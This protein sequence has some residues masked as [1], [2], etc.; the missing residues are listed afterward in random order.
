VN[1]FWHQKIEDLESALPPYIRL[2][3]LPNYGSVK[4]RL[5]T[6]GSVHRDIE[7]EITDWQQKIKNRIEENVIA[8]EDLKIEDVLGRL[9]LDKK[10]NVATAESCTGGMIGSRISDV[11]GSS[12]YFKGAVVSYAY[13]VK[14]EVLGVDPE[15]LL[16]E[17]AVSEY[18]V[19]KM[20]QEVLNVMNAEVSVAVSGILGPGGATDEKPLGTVWMA[21]A[22]K[23]KTHSKVFHF[24]YDR[25]R[26][27][28]SVVQAALIGLI[29][30]IQ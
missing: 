16:R 13:D 12:R 23:E 24:R 28:E 3:Y 15:H 6:H 25:W 5:T 7:K 8:E 18:T 26:N 10:L 29:K 14:S 2:A 11:P 20:A 1:L 4:L 30:F 21:W 9:L 22:S 19:K 17:G 27:K